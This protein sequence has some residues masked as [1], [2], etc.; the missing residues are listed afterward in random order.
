MQTLEVKGLGKKLL[1]Q[2]ILD[3]IRFGYKELRLEVY[4]S[5]IAARKLYEKLGFSY[6]GEGEEITLPNG[7]RRR[8]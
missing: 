5:N 7:E 1:K 6:V 3:S 8:V 4:K 2:V